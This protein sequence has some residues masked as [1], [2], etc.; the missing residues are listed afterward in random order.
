MAWQQQTIEVVGV[1]ASVPVATERGLRFR[2][3]VE[4]VLTKDAIVPQRISLNYYQAAA[5]GH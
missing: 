1:V 3:D 5:E 4:T 2:F